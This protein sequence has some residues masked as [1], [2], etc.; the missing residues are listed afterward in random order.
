M[1]FV[2]K[3]FNSILDC[4]CLPP[5]LPHANTN[6]QI[7]NL[8]DKLASSMCILHLHRFVK[9][10]FFLPFSL[11]S[12]RCAS[13]LAKSFER[14]TWPASCYAI[15]M[16][17]Q[18]RRKMGGGKKSVQFA[19]GPDI[20]ISCFHLGY[21]QPTNVWLW[22]Y[23]YAQHNARVRLCIWRALYTSR[24]EWAKCKRVAIIVAEVVLWIV[25]LAKM[26]RKATA[27]S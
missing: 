6:L 21:V 22:I 18:E 9:R 24:C 20:I 10:S 13:A 1:L 7:N 11:L 3:L 14:K 4:R 16:Y 17:M 25:A 23:S 19:P 5:F 8:C 15:K 12:S 2:C 26:Y 27:R